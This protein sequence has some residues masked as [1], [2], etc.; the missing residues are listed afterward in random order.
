MQFT[1]VGDDRIPL[2][3]TREDWRTR[4]DF[5]PRKSL[6]VIL[7]LAAHTEPIEKSYWEEFTKRGIETL[8]LIARFESG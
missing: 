2:P 4:V 5:D 8:H 7:Y 6:G 3:G 1:G